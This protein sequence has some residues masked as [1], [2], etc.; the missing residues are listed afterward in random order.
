M[1]RV[2]WVLAVICSTLC[3]CNGATP[4]S[5]SVPLV[6][7]TVR[8]AVTRQPVADVVVRLRSS[9]AP[10]TN[11][12][13][14]RTGADGIFAVPVAGRTVYTFAHPEYAVR[15]AYYSDDVPAPTGGDADVLLYKGGNVLVRVLNDD[16]THA[17]NSPVR[18]RGQDESGFG[19]G[20]FG[21]FRGTAVDGE[22][23]FT[24]VPCSGTAMVATAPRSRAAFGSQS[25]SEPFTPAPGTQ[26]TVT[27]MLDKGASLTI[28]FPTPESKDS[29]EIRGISVEGGHIMRAIFS[30]RNFTFSE[31]EAR[32]D[33]IEQGTYIIEVIGKSFGAVSTNVSIGAKGAL[34]ID[35]P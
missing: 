27:V 2:S 5:S 34:T 9:G 7:G 6:R 12:P 10:D 1:T 29:V 15:Q 4:S 35:V 17:A 11:P 31:C 24:N 8:D 22:V 26:T 25:T 23:V 14:C 18:L 28:R 19:R 16:G 21:M 13:V 20:A 3:L 30:A 33:N 32:L